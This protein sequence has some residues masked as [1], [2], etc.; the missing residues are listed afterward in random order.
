[1]LNLLRLG[2]G[3]AVVLA[4][5]SANLWRE[6]RTE[7]QLT[8]ELQ[9]QRIEPGKPDPGTALAAR[10]INALPGSL[11]FASNERDDAQELPPPAPAPGPAVVINPVGEYVNTPE[12]DLMKDPEYR[13][14][15]SSQQRMR[16]KRTYTDVAEELDLSAAETEKLFDILVEQQLGGRNGS[17]EA[18]RA[19]L[20][21]GRQNKWQEYQQ[22]LSARNRAVEMTGMLAISGHPLT[23]A[24]RRPLTEALIDEEKYVRQQQSVL[25]RPALMTPE[26]RAQQREEEVNRQEES[27]RRYLDAAAPY[28]SPQQL[29]LVR[30]TLEWQIAM[31][32]ASARWQRERLQSGA[33]PR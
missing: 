23:E 33:P 10:N 3:L 21:P 4:F 30:E 20:G 13:K 2:T 17:E 14:G 28:M 5:V 1:M 19:L 15:R 6:L 16:L 11:A 22:T 9:A 8:A 26:F 27:N 12:R 18:L 7:R 25:S 32:R 31:S 29:A 24:Q